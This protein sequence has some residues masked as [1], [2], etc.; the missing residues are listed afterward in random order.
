MPSD[1]EPVV[2][3]LAFVHGRKR[4]LNGELVVVFTQ[5]TD[6][7]HFLKVLR[8][9]FSEN[10]NVMIG[11]VKGRPHQSGHTGIHTDVF[12]IDV[13][14]IDGCRHQNTMRSGHIA[15]AFDKKSRHKSISLFK[16]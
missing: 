7:I 3:V 14:L 2:R 16:I 10:G 1:V 6:H 12:S 13:F 5:R 8:W 4:A 11:A 9:M 15:A